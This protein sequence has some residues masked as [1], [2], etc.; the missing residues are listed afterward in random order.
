MSKSTPKL[1][2]DATSGAFVMLDTVN[3]ESALTLASKSTQKHHKTC[4]A[5]PINQNP[6]PGSDDYYRLQTMNSKK[7]NK[8]GKRVSRKKKSV[9]MKPLPRDWKWSGMGEFIPLI[10]HWITQG[11]VTSTE[12]TALAYLTLLRSMSDARGVNSCYRDYDRLKQLMDEYRPEF[13]EACGQIQ[14]L[15]DTYFPDF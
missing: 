1:A 13:P 8:R 11:N 6:I 14:K 9:A 15:F 7:D 12:S 3:T 2:Y 4:S 10:E 5:P